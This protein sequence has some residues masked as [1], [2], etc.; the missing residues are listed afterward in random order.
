MTAIYALLEL[1]RLHLSTRSGETRHSRDSQAQTR[2]ISQTTCTSA[3]CRM[4]KRSQTLTCRLLRSTLIS[5]S[6]PT[7]TNRKACGTS[8]RMTKSKRLRFV[9]SCGPAICS[10]TA[11]VPTSLEAS[12][13]G[14]GSKTVT[15]T[16]LSS[17]CT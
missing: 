8:C 11:R 1:S 14:T 13:M 6:Q 15:C 12:T 17:E 10:T 16:S 2:W 3:T 5:W 4:N 7:S 9:L